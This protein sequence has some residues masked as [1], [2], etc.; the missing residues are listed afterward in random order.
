M[1]FYLFPPS[2]MGVG[3]RAPFQDCPQTKKLA[4]IPVAFMALLK[5]PVFLQYCMSCSFPFSTL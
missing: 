2:L 5:V 3:E 1:I 4:V